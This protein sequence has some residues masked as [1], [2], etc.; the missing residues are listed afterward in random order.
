[1]SDWPEGRQLSNGNFGYLISELA[2]PLNY[3]GK[4]VLPAYLQLIRHSNTLPPVLTGF[5]QANYLNFW[6]Q[7]DER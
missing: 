4:A 7:A 3:W 2:V 6:C 5:T 1:M